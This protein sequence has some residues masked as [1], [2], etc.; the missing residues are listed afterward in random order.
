MA[1]I[2]AEQRA[3]QETV[4]IPVAVLKA[5]GKEVG[6][7]ARRQVD[8]YIPLAR[9]LWDEYGRE[10]RVVAVV[11]LGAMELAAPEKMLPLLMELC[12]TCHTWEDADQFAMNAL[13]PIVRNDPE[14]WLPAVEP[15]LSDENKWLRRVG[16][17]MCPDGEVPRL[18]PAV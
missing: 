9:I 13:E 8:E 15:W 6:K 12:G 1:G 18:C 10:G 3:R 17:I 16:I 11:P 14:T 2:K 4:G 7:V 5:I